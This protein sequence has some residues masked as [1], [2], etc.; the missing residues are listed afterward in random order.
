MTGSGLGAAVFGCAGPELTPDEAAFFRDADQFGFILFSRNLAAPDQIRRLCSD[1]RAA[2][3]WGAPIFIDQEGGRV[4]RLRPPLARD[5]SAPLDMART[6]GEAAPR[7]FWLRYRIIAA[8][9]R[10]LGIDG[11]CAPLADMAEDGTHPVLKNRCYGTDPATVTQ[12]ARAV[13]EAHLA[14]G[15]LP[16]LKH[17]PGHGLARVDSH[18]DLP[19]VSADRATLEAHDFAPFRALN[20]LPL[21]MSAHLVFDAID[22]ARPATISPPAIAMIR[23]DIGFDGLLMTDD[24][25]MQALSGTVA[26]RSAAA[27]AAGCDLVLHCNGNLTEMHAVASATGAMHDAARDRA[28]RALEARRP[29]DP[30][31]IAELEAELDALQRG[32]GAD[33][34]NRSRQL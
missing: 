7:G 19:R 11:N 9:L 16:V 13:A 34:R 23:D 24:I 30:V 22:P 2:V 25:S 18:L 31:D 20:D 10:S 26:E 5:W 12:I 6:L 3:G 14:G 21:G 15:V 28:H 1:L 27:I 33:D 32:A 17:I 4:Q 8:E 29:P